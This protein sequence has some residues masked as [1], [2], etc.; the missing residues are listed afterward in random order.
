MNPSSPTPSRNTPL[1]AAR[2]GHAT[3]PWLKAASSEAYQSLRD[4]QGKV[5]PWFEAA[6]QDQP[7]IARALAQEHAQHRSHAAQVQALFA[8]LPDLH[9]F[10]SEQLTQAIKA[11]FDLDVEVSNTYLVDARLIQTEHAIDARQAV[12]RATR[13]L[14]QWALHNFDADACA[15]DGMDAPQALL[16][17][18]V[19]LDHRRFMGTVPLTNTVAIPA[20]AFAELCR[21][22]DIGGRYHKQVYD[23][24]YP[25]PT[26]DQGPHE[27]A[28][29]VYETLARAEQSAFR[30][31]LHSA[32]LQGHISQGFYDAALAAPLDAPLPHTGSSLTFSLLTLWE[33][34]IV[35]MAVLQLQPDSGSQNA[36]V[37]LYNPDDPHAPL[38]EY[39]SLDTL[40]AALR[41]ALLL[42]SHYLDNCLAARDKPS[43]QQKLQD[44]LTPMG[45]STRGL[46][47]RVT[48]PQA[49]LEPI[50]HKA[51]YS[52]LGTLVTQKVARHE[53]D[54][55]FHAVPTWAVDLLSAKRHREAIAG[56]V[57]TT[58][59]IAGFFVPGLGEA[60]LA[61]CIAQ[62][63]Y[64][65]YE[66]IESWTNDDREQAHRYLIDVMENTATL[67]AWAAAGYVVKEGIGAV[68]AGNPEAP[69]RE[70]PEVDTPSFIEELEEVHLPDGDTRLW[71]PDLAPFAHD[72]PLPEGLEPDE[73]GLYTHAGK[74]W[75]MLE[76]QLYAVKQAQPSN[77]YRIEHPRRPQ[78]YTPALQHNGA[79]AWLHELDR[80]LAWQGLALFRRAGH[81][82]GA[83]DDA[84][85]TRIL[86]ACDIDEAVLR[87]S[88][89]DSQ[90]LPALLEDTLI[91][92]NLDQQIGQLPADAEPGL[93]GA[94]FEARY[95]QL[96][97]TQAP[98][99][100]VIQHVYPQ[101]PDAITQELLRNANPL[102]LQQ[103]V[104]GRVPLR[105]GQEIHLYQAN[106]RLT[107]A[108]EG[109]YLQSLRNWDTDQ[110]IVQTLGQL[111]GWPAE[112]SLV[113]EQ[114]QHSPIQLTRIGPPDRLGHTTI[115]SARAGYIVLGNDQPDAR[116]VA[117]TS[118]YSA[119]F[120]VLTAAQREALSIVDEQGL[121]HLVQ[122]APPMPR[123]ALRKVLGMQA[124]R[125]GFRS[126]LRLA[127]GR[128]GY[129]LGGMRPRVASI[130]RHTL[131]SSI[132]QIG[133]HAPN[134]RPAEQILTALEHRALTRA[135][136][137]DRLSTLLEQRDELHSRLADWRRIAALTPRQVPDDLER[138][139]NA[140]AQ[141]WYERAFLTPTDIAP[142]LRLERL[143][144]DD[145]PLSLPDFFTSSVTGLQLIETAPE[146]FAGWSH[147]GP[148]LNALLRQFANLR[149]LEIS[150]AYRPEALPSPFQF[151]L[152]VI[153]QHLPALES[154]SLTH[155]NISLSSTDID[156]LAGLTHLR[157]LDL[158]GNRLSEQ[159]PPRF[160]EIALDYLG[161]DNL[162]LDHWPEGLGFNAVTQIR[163]IGLRNNQITMLPRFL[164]DNRINLA[165]HAVLSLQGND[166]FEDDLLRVMMSEDGRAS[167]FEV[168]RSEDFSARLA[169]RL[170][171][172][173]LLRNAIDD[174]VNASSSSAPVSQAVMATRTRVATA[175]NEFWHYQEIGLTRAAL[176]L[177]DIALEH[178][179]RL[180]PA[181]FT[182]Q[183]HN[184]ALER[185][186]GSTAQLDGLFRQFPQVTRLSVD[187][188]QQA[189]QTLPSAL[190]RLPG[191]TDIAL[192][193]AGLVIDQQVINALGRLPTLNSLDLTGNR[194]GLITRAPAALQT[195]RRLDLNA[196]GL[197]QWPS[198]V[199]SLLPLELLDLSENRL[200]E[201]PA[202][203]LA[204]LD[205]NFP[206]SSILLFSNPLSDEAVMRARASSDSQ[207]SFTF[208]IDLSDSMSESSTEGAMGGHFHL[209]FLDPAA[210]APNLQDWL[211]ASDVENEALKE[212][213]DALQASGNAGNLLALVGRLRN[214]APYQNGKSRVAFCARVRKVLVSAVVNPDD[215]ALFNHQASEALLQENGDQ[216]CHDGALL[217]FQNIELYIA[218][219]RLQFDAADT[220]GNLYRE[221]RRLYRLQALDEIAKSETARRDEA[222]VRLTYRR[223]LNTP[224]D[225]G[226]PEDTLRYAISASIDELAHAE[227]QVQRGELGEDFLNFAAA[228]AQW[229]QHLRQAYAGR[230][231]EIEQSYQAQVVDLP[232]QFPDR[233]LDTLTEEFT[234]L[235]RSKQAREARLIRELTSFANPDRRPRS[236]TE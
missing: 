107:R 180:L 45:W 160:N 200:T 192:R 197:E 11:R 227:L 32:W 73:T 179:P 195:L 167:R 58:L 33:V 13:S 23:I 4:A 190:L 220:E 194:M 68:L 74:R 63:G 132:R 22:L 234:A 223:E 130:S 72:T 7:D 77:A 44:R 28:L 113:L 87:R 123:S 225:L 121:R 212:C 56:K 52:F 35:G 31:S 182:E 64:E 136:I 59:N 119:L 101:L 114:R 207:H 1:H 189:E 20:H 67:A 222:E 201:L 61:V 96:P 53:K 183:V 65:V 109:V 134:P 21:T 166:L 150:R 97:A 154:L 90:R 191:L 147:H 139:L 219:Q 118:L 138:V 112:I 60:M 143:S 198:W 205:N 137:A 165:D 9:T 57:L 184:L 172:R 148:H 42:D 229:V 95:R 232:E 46:H 50:P 157:R 135:E 106:V 164:L 75:L 115:V 171:R 199:D 5:P 142:P 221:L 94:E 92:F 103:L 151:S 235:E 233:P 173:Q 162:A 145:F 27:A 149:S 155:Q 48:D 51:R 226:Q 108:Y 85:A 216:T 224:L 228:N 146:N 188:Y 62:L 10:A 82:S 210:D 3:P 163:H 141:H 36:R 91:R 16:K 70:I 129:P 34:E 69:V 125:P 214:A 204:N 208:G 17:K 49:T 39:A 161:L 209:P 116:V 176:R 236:S 127:D 158:S 86:Q 98:G 14:L 217:V 153:A 215:L 41:D 71:K 18:S 38:K 181:F 177:N 47:E 100:S 211:L 186:S 111:P 81:L 169:L 187:A 104:A 54:A 196:M 230:F 40:E 140:I 30:Q 231:A 193:N 144:L 66:G 124:V 131:L 93:P 8:S 110:L 2:I 159:Y 43:I 26:G 19:V 122:Q 102:E 88:V 168:D 89:A 120:E 175:L 78:A 37:A 15:A 55:L 25:A 80:P 128:L 105:I 202:H 218:N 156:S 126:P 170:E 12:D 6:L 76:G 117:H 213:W 29:Q 24:Y 206:I 133:Q 203:I 174:Y 99:A 185:V 84:T 83:F 178:F 79:G 152:P